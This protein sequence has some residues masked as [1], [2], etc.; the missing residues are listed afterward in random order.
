LVT[1]GQLI[2]PAAAALLGVAVTVV[3]NMVLGR[4]QE[5][6]AEWRELITIRRA[7]YAEVWRVLMLAREHSLQT[8]DEEERL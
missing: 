4:R 2:V 6:L 3:S 1:T 7:V 5:K 8:P